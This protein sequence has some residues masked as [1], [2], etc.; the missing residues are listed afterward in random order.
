MKSIK[1]YF[2]VTSND[3]DEY[4]ERKNKKLKYFHDEV[5]DIIPRI[6][7][8]SG[9][10]E[11]FKNDLEEVERCYNN[12]SFETNFLKESDENIESLF[13]QYCKEAGHDRIDWKKI[14]EILKDVDSIILKL[15]FEYNRPRPIN[16]F[17]KESDFKLKYKKSPSFP[18]GHT[19]IS[20]F[21]CDVLSHNFPEMRQD[22]QTLASLIGQSR[23]EN[24]VHF[25][26]DIEFGRIVGETLADSFINDNSSIY[27][28][29]KI[30]ENHRKNF[31]SHILSVNNKNL[32]ENIAYFLHRTNQ[33]ENYNIDFKTC[34]DASKNFI[35]GY[36][37][38]YVSDNNHIISQ[39]SSMIA[40]HKI[41]SIDN[42]YKIRY[43][44]EMFEPSIL[45]RGKPGELR[46]YP[47]S[48]PHGLKFAEENEIYECL[49]NL[50]KI[51]ISPW[52][53]HICY[54][55]I[56]PF[57][58]GN[59]RSGRIMLLSDLNYDFEKINELIDGDYLKNLVIPMTDNLNNI[60][61]ILK[62]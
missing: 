54:E 48:S 30:K 37:L 52:D 16:Y 60:K 25:P 42:I 43:I 34:K 32:I 3:T 11:K 58:D 36:P 27:L 19:A 17:E 14:D 44:H 59:G 18:S 15:K 46:S 28:N 62:M 20:Y 41:G 13:K 50:F 51:N 61:K 39:L 5:L 29:K 7:Y 6:N 53:K 8:P 26:T 45:K 40:S 22:L 21:L 4:S 2:D 55:W 33:I 35:A 24:A 57:C 23:I 12:P 49:K 1:E 47:H 56:H 38:K 9:N 10:T 31:I